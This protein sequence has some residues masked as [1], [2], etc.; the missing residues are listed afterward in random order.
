MKFLKFFLVFLFLF[1]IFFS[2]KGITY[3]NNE[4]VAENSALVEETNVASPSATP[5]NSFELFWPLV[6]G[7]TRGDSM[8]FLKIWK[9]N[10]RGLLI[11]GAPQ[12]ADYQTLRGTKRVLEVESLFNNSKFDLATE[13]ESSANNYLKNALDSLKV[14]SEIPDD[15]KVSIKN[16]MDNLIKLVDQLNVGTKEQKN[17]NEQINLTHTLIEDLLKVVSK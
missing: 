10:I 9:E 16:R 7:K 3:A 14:M 13:T 15:V 1:V 8:Y 6:A 4:E 5:I 11:F 12:K 2:F 17:L